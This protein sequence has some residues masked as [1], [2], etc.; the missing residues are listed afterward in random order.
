MAY[1]KL[2]FRLQQLRFEHAQHPSRTSCRNVK[3]HR[4]PHFDI[5]TYV[6]LL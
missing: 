6:L 5:I 2:S 3:A 1:Y 4:Q